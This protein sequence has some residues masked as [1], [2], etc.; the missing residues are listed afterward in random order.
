MIV[1]DERAY[2]AAGDIARHERFSREAGINAPR[3]E[4]GR[5]GRNRNL[6]PLHR[7]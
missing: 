2:L 6:D 3:I 1:V 7:R 4:R 5:N